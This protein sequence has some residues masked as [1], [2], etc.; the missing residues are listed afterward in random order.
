[1]LSQTPSAVG[2]LASEGLES[3]ALM[4]AAEPCPAEVVDRWALGRAGD[5]QRLRSD[6]DHGARDDQR[7][8]AGWIRMWCPIGVPVPGAALFVLDRW[9]RPV[10][11]GRGGQSC[12]WPAVVSA[13]GYVRRAGLSGVSVRRLPPFGGAGSPGAADVSHRRPGAAWGADGQLRYAG[14]C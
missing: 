8:A 7:T 6:R 12:T 9:L 2:V 5:D 3:A 10:P 11:A 13:L 4:V 14:A 1:M